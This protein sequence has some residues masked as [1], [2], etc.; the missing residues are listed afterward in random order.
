MDLSTIMHDTAYTY[1]IAIGWT[2]IAGLYYKCL[3]TFA[4]G[5]HQG[6]MHGEGK[7]RVNAARK[8]VY[9]HA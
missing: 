5:D 8:C 1:I 4:L 9:T 2:E 6:C 7:L 3:Y